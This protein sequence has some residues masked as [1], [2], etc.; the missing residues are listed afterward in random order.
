MFEVRV[1]RRAARCR[2]ASQS[3]SSC[4]S[5][6]CRRNPAGSVLAELEKAGTGTRP[7]LKRL[8][9]NL[10]RQQYTDGVIDDLL[11]R[12]G[13]TYDDLARA[14]EPGGDQEPSILKGIYH[15]VPGR[16]EML[17]AWMASDDRDETIAAKGAVAELV[18]LVSRESGSSSTRLT[19]WPSCGPSRC[20]TCWSASSETT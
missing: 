9:R 10:L 12:E 14:A 6:A 1:G 18:K 15:D 11:E 7:Q 5:P 19:A 20:D 16:D 3:P 2:R 17:A 13:V 8:A 4:T